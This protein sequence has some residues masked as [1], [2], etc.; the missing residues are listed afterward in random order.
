MSDTDSVNY[1]LPNSPGG[2]EENKSDESNP[3]TVASMAETAKD[4]CISELERKLNL[5]LHLLAKKDTST[6]TKEEKE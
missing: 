1:Q 5:V 3:F 6:E 4:C 2:V